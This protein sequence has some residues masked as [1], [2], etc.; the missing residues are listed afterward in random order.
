MV[1]GLLLQISMVLDDSENCKLDDY[2]RE[3][4]LANFSLF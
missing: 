1:K 3:Y 2:E 4:N